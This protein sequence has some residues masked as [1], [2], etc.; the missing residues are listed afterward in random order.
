MNESWVNSVIVGPEA[1]LI[2]LYTDADDTNLYF[3]GFLIALTEAVFVFCSFD[4]TG[5]FEE[6][7]FGLL[8]HILQVSE[9]KV[10]L[11]S[12]SPTI[13]K[14]KT[15]VDEKMIKSINDQCNDF[16]GCMR[17]LQ[18]QGEVIGVVD[19]NG[20]EVYGIIESVSEQ[21]VLVKSYSASGHSD[22][23]MQIR[24]SSIMRIDAMGPRHQKVTF[25][26]QR[27]GTD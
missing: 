23:E 17:F 15:Y 22:G 7:Q 25:S 13:G 20:D 8:E 5:V 26:S 1:R 18:K 24:K 19:F 2:A 9:D 27:K 4:P 10:K 3:P 11:R 6:V 16:D 21:W 14:V 12:L